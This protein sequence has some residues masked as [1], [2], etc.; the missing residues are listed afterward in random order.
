MTLKSVRESLG[1]SQVG[2]DRLAGLTR[3]TVNQI[4]AGHNEN[5]SLAIALALTEALRNAGARGVT[6]E[7]LFATAKAV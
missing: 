3:G 5:P 6:V 1:L 4:E 2:L 7:S